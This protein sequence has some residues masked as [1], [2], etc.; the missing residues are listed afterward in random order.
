MIVP[1]KKLTVITLSDNEGKLLDALGRLGV[2]QL[3]KLDETEFVGFKEAA[4][5][6]IREYESL[7]ER[8]RSLQGKLG[9]TPRGARRLDKVKAPI[10]ELRASIEEFEKK[11]AALEGKLEEA[12]ERLK[13]LE[14]AKPTLQILKEQKVNPGDIGE[15]KHIFA[16]AGIAKAQLMPSLRLRLKARKD[17]T[18]REAAISPKETFVYVAGLVE[19]KPWIEKLLATVEFKEFKLPQGMPGKVDEAI[20][21]VEEETIRLREEIKG[22]EGEWESLRREFAAKAGS[23]EAA[24]TYSLDISLAQSHLLRSKMMTILQGWV[25]EDRM[26]D[27]SAFLER[28]N[29]DVGGSIAFSYEEPLPD[30]EVP[31]VMKNPKLFRAYETLTRQYGYPDPKESDPTVIST[32]LWITMFGIMFPDFGEGLV[33]LGLGVLFAYVLKKPLMGINFARLGRLMIGLGISAIIFGLLVGEFFLMEVHPLWP[34]LM[35]AWVKYPSNV[36]WLIK[37]AVFFGIAQIILALIMSIRNHLRA[38]EKM[39]ALLGERGL[40]GLITF[41]GIVIVAFEFLGISIL[42]GIAFPELGLNVIQHWTIAIPI[43]GIIAIVVKP[44]LAG[45]GATMSL[46]VLI[47]TLISFFANMLSYARIAGFCIAHAAFALVVAELLHSNPALGIGLGLIF[48]NA[49]AL[50][51]ELMVVMIQALRL[52]YYEFSTKFFKGT[53]IPYTPYR[54]RA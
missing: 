32:I 52:L 1:V 30:E 47:E 15:F 45:E 23:L 10:G 36:I 12:K 14:D 50:T 16:K 21:W 11:V 38:G 20:R 17:V 18:F 26:K 28:L 37:I 43:A 24:V 41:I 2:V 40:A 29:K 7:Y 54:I 27:L 5:E 9:V 13:A 35:P 39:E 25:P 31:T 33:I 3:R 4:S 42:P 46:G 19:L 44:I 22:L 6:E 34:G 8:L 48:L 49:F 51:L 53:G